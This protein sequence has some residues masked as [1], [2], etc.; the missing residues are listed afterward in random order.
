MQ[1]WQILREAVE[2]VG[3]KV[4]AAKLHVSTAL[5][6]KWSQETGPAGTGSGALNPLDRV[7]TILQTTN[8]TRLVSWLCHAAGGF[9]V[10]NPDFDA[11]NQA[12][13]LLAST[14]K[15][16]EEFSNV[17]STISRSVENDGQITPDEADG[18]RQSWEELKS[19]G[20]CFVVACET[21]LYARIG[22]Q[23]SDGV[24]PPR[25]R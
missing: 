8:D 17:L 20:E 15:V 2:Q 9:F 13:A 25:E 7:R 18:I 14:Q 24:A 16:V 23:A 21:G 10:E 4:L 1:S 11:E 12:A 22:E 5:V 6:Y 19:C 3:A